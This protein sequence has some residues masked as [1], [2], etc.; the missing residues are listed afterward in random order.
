MKQ[1]VKMVEYYLLNGFDYHTALR[2]TAQDYNAS[3]EVIR[4]RYEKQKQVD[5]LKF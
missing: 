4:A 5:E 1:V 2:L 3:I